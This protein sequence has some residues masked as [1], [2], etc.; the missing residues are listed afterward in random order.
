[1]VKDSYEID[2]MTRKFGLALKADGILKD[3]EEVNGK[4][5]NR[6]YMATKMGFYL[7]ISGH[8]IKSITDKETL[9]KRL[10]V[11]VD[12]KSY[13]EDPDDQTKVFIK[14]KFALAAMY[15]FNKKTKR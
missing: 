4:P 1:M 11:S 14:T 7:D 5:F 9:W 15:D 10:N 2:G 12:D 13:S 6:D 8:S 3:D